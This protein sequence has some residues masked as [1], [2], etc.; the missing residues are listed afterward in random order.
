MPIRTLL[1]CFLMAFE[2]CAIAHPGQTTDNPSPHTA[3]ADAINTGDTAPSYDSKYARGTKNMPGVSSNSTPEDDARPGQYFFLLGANAFAH[4]DYAHAV[5]M[6]KVAAS[7]AYKPAEYNLG[8]MYALGQGVAADPSRAMAWMALAAERGDTRYID[9]REVVYAQLAQEQF[10]QANVIW[11]ELKKTYGDE[12]ALR[13]AKA[14]WAEVRS[15]IT[16]SHVGFVGHLDVG[17][18]YQGVADHRPRLPAASSSG[19][20]FAGGDEVDGSI[21]YRQLRESKNP[22]DPKFERQPVGTATVEDLIPV[23]TPS[24]PANETATDK[25]DASKH[26]L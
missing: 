9:A 22:Y 3:D 24:R 19:D 2:V 20:I 6:Y 12:V 5:E 10:D 14:R 21:A 8:I 16:G 7:W 11:R 1:S 18:P 15:N 17:T 25:V 26:N 13:R 23:K 4:K